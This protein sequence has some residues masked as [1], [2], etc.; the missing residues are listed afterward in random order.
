MEILKDLFDEKI[1]EIISLFMENPEKQ[2]SLTQVSNSTKVNV[3]TTF[4]IL[5]KLV[6]KEF[7]K[8]TVIGKIKVYQLEKSKKT[9]EL[10]QILKGGKEEPLQEFIK[11]ISPH[12]R[13]KKIILESRESNNAKI[14]IIGDFLPTE[15]INRLCEEIKNKYNFRISFVEISE[16]Q[17]IKLREFKNYELDKKII[18][19]KKPLQA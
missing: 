15:K 16:N 19:E 11:Q 2:Y 4:R 17:Y 1:I 6:A 14:L 7:L 5:N 12:P 3:A 10:I 8:T 18:W 9:L 13:I